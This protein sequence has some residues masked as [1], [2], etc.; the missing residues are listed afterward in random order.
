MISY[1]QMLTGLFCS[2]GTALQNCRTIDSFNSIGDE[3]YMMSGS[4]L[5][6]GIPHM[7][8]AYAFV[9]PELAQFHKIKVLCCYLRCGRI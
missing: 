9:L 2:C 4:H 5:H 7:I 6:R 3:G 8:E 1:P